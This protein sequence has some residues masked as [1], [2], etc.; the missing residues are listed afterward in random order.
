[1]LRVTDLLEN[2]PVGQLA[3]LLEVEGLRM[4][5]QWVNHIAVTAVAPE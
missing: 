2:L 1:M 3:K 4:V 5:E